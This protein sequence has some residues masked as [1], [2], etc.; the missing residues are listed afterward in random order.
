LGIDAFEL[1]V[2]LSADEQLVVMHDATVDRTTD[3]S[4]SL[5]SFTAAE[6]ALLDARAE[7]PD[8]PAR[9]GVPTLAQLLE[10]IP[11]ASQWELE[12]KSDAPD[13]MERVCRQLARFVEEYELRG[14][15]TV[16]SFDPVALEL[17]AVAAPDLPRCYIARFDTLDSL[18]T[19]RELG[20][21][22]VAIP[23][24]TGSAAMVAASRA[25]G[26]RVAGWQ[27]NSPE[28]I[29]TLVGW[30]VDQITTDFPTMAL[31]T[32]RQG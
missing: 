28:D 9:V 31:G 32:L 16:T 3:G 24:K 17:I 7:H 20:C 11:N 6:L 13:R 19:A 12:I 21:A 2:R 23:L 14:R 8:W 22:Q 25:A 27:G 26:M 1:D 18:E 10:E 29:R 4:G 5:S 30:G 15:A